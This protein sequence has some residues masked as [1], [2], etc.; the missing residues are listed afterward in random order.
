[1]DKQRFESALHYVQNSAHIQNGIGTLH[2]KTM[3][4]VLKKYFEPYSDN[5]ETK[6]GDYVADIVGEHGI[7]EI[8]TRAFERLNKKL[9]VFLE[10]ARTTVVYPV[11]VCNTICRIDEN[12]E[13][14]RRKSPV[15]GSML[16]LFDELYKICA[17]L[18]SER[19]RICVMLVKTDEYRKV[20]SRKQSRKGFMRLE[21]VPTELVDEIY[22]DCPSGFA[23]FFPDNLK[24]PYTCAE[25][26]A[27]TGINQDTARLMLYTFTKADIINR[28]GKR[29]NAYLY[30][31][32]DFSSQG[33]HNGHYF[34]RGDC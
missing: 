5:H 32:P 1:M 13:I 10:Y 29:G 15:T 22:I 27:E 33:E 8:Q 30:T 12:G 3:H 6:I 34:T 16:T 31:L 24:S 9:A 23:A 7:I 18:K 14:M 26:A 25:Y 28:V 17:H 11:S 20:C 21:R 4:A 19:L 2:E